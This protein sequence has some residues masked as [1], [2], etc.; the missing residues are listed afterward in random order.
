[1]LNIYLI[2]RSDKNEF[3]YDEY[4]SA[5]VVS[6]CAESASF[7]HPCPECLGEDD[8]SISRYM[9][10][11]TYWVEH[12]DIWGNSLVDQDIWTSPD[13]VNVKFIGKADIGYKSGNIICANFSGVCE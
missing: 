4:K 12:G 5:V 13:K 10:N 8:K 9:W 3:D 2:S 7:I 1:M 11:G 6:E